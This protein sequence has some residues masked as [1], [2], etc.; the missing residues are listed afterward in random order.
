MLP[1]LIAAFGAAPDPMRAMNRFEDL[2]L[3]LPTG[4]NFFRLLE[5]RPVL[6]EHLAAILSH[7]PPLAEQFGAARRTCST[8]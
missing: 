8:A 4:V 2:I 5:A 6:A 3:K 1:E 7:A